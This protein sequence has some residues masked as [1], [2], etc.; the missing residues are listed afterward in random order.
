MNEQTAVYPVPTVA[1][2]EEKQG[3]DLRDFSANSDTS[4][5]LAKV[6]LSD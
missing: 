3:C 6:E 1:A 4:I 5:L 2:G